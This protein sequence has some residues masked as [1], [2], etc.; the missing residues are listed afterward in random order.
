MAERTP[1]EVFDDISLRHK[2]IRDNNDLVVRL[3]KELHLALSSLEIAH[4]GLTGPNPT[5]SAAAIGA[6]ADDIDRISQSMQASVVKTV[7]A[8]RKK[9]IQD[10]TDLKE[11][12][13]L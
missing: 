8:D 11:I 7:D 13:G 1:Q 10:M 2:H 6:I 4:A 5:A 3:S 12:L 9:L